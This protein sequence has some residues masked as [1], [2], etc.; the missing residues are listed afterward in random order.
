M[1]RGLNTP[2]MANEHALSS[3]SDKAQPGFGTNAHRAWMPLKDLFY[4]Y[5]LGP[6]AASSGEFGPENEYLFTYTS[7][8][9]EATEQEVSDHNNSLLPSR[10]NSHYFTDV[11][12]TDPEKEYIKDGINDSDLA[13]LLD[14][15]DKTQNWDN[16][17]QTREAIVR[18]P[19]AAAWQ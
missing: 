4:S 11:D 14:K 5:D 1:S 13:I 10:E 16:I 17:S 18:H 15:I 9:Y 6:E 7:P 2:I 3:F 8:R 12:S 19:H